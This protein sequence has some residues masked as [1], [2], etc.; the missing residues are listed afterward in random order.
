[1]DELHG[2]RPFT[3]AGSDAFHRTVP[4]I[5]H[6]KKPGNIGLEQ[7]GIPF[8]RPSLGALVGKKQCNA[9]IPHPHLLKQVKRLFGRIACYHTV[10]CTVLRPQA[11]FNRPKTSESSSTLSKIGFAMIGLSLVK[12]MISDLYA[13]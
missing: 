9:V 3:D 8:E 4:H 2:D 6:G 5:A 13:A 11:A 7:K 1:M 10:F 12:Q